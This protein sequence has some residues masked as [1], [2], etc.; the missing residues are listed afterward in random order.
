MSEKK[1]KLHSFIHRFRYILYPI[2]SIGFTFSLLTFLSNFVEPL[3]TM[4]E[5]YSIPWYLS[6]FVPLVSGAIGFMHAGMD[7][8]FNP[9]LRR[10]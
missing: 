2:L 6:L 7:E 8:V 1:G 9:R 5:V 3:K 10:V 4:N